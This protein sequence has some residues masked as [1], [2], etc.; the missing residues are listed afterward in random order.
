MK[1]KQDKTVS[2]SVEQLVI[3]TYTMDKYEDLPMFAE[4]RMH[5]LSCGNPYPNK[6]ILSSREKEK[7][8]KSYTLIYLENEYV[9]IGILPEIGGRIFS[10][11]DKKTGYDYLYRQHVIKP[12]FIGVLGAWISGGI[13]FNF[14]FHHRPSTFMPVDYTVEKE[15]D[16]SATVWLSEHDPF[17]RMKGLVGIRLRPEATYFETQVK[18]QNRTSLRHSFL[19]WEN[20]AVP[21]NTDYELFFPPDV[22]H[23]YF[24]YR[25]SA[26][27]FP[28]ASYGEYN[29][30]RF[31]KEGTDISKHKNT[32]HSTS[33]FSASSKYD[34][35]GGYDRG[36]R[37]GIIHVADHNV[38]VGKKMFTWGYNQLS[39]SWGGALTDTDGTYCELMAGSYSNSQPDFTFIEPYETKCFSQY[40]Y[41]IAD[42]GNATYANLS[43]AV[44]LEKG[45]LKVQPTSAYKNVK[46][47]L[48]SEGKEIFSTFSDLTPGS[49]AAFEVPDYSEDCFDITLGSILHFEMRRK[50]EKRTPVLFPEVPFPKELDTAEKRYLAGVH[51]LQYRCV[52]ESPKAYFESA[53]ALDAGYTPAL[54]ALGELALRAGDYDDAEKNLE[55]AL[56][57]LTVYNFN[58]ESGKVSYLLGLAYLGL[59]KTD[60]AYDAFYKSTWNEAQVSAGMTR[61]ACIDG[62]R[63]DYGEML[64]HSERALSFNVENAVAAALNIAAEL[65]LGN[66]EAAFEKI[67]AALKLDPLNYLVRYLAV[68]AGA[69]SEKDFYGALKSS[70]SQTCLDVA[71]D[72]MSFGFKAEATALLRG[73]LNYTDDIAPTVRYLLG[74]KS[75]GIGKHRTFPFRPE[76]AAVLEKGN[77]ETSKYLLGCLYYGA[78]RYEKAAELWRRCGN[79]EALRNLAVYSYR[80]GDIKATFDYLAKARALNPSSEQLIYETV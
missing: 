80:Q 1:N 49:V 68:T 10:A 64:W 14:P 34:F 57:R 59:G 33:Y 72:L 45:V 66:K 79:W 55:K 2:V 32:Y 77:D 74:E 40:W 13:E 38:S 7:K 73:L 27:G 28:I 26:A 30:F 70:P 42:L 61:V 12:S 44:R 20:A 56:A 25:R 18:V 29:G 47:T 46:I 8:D 31:D 50:T 76:E 19:W 24:H 17:D 6:V 52:N 11:T 75:E 23:V 15:E 60:K 69:M 37:C 9:K 5:Q 65:R 63:G 36:K 54:T 51:L 16:G 43:A 4:N 71:F 21:A 67:K 41:P 35:F 53:L 58:P 48:R 22:D 3:P 62:L 39:R 78:K